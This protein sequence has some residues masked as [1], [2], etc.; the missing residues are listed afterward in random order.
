MKRLAAA[1]AALACACGEGRSRFD[2]GDPARMDRPVWEQ[3]VA[4]RDAAAEAPEDALALL[5]LGMA[6]D[7]NGLYDLAREVY[8]EAARLDPE[9]ARAHYHLGRMHQTLGDF[10]LALAALDRAA[11]LAPEYEPVHWRRGVVCLD[12]ARLDEAQAHFERARELAPGSVSGPVGLARVALQRG[13]AQRAVAL[14]EELLAAHPRERYARDLLAR[15]WQRLG[16]PERASSIA[17]AGEWSTAAWTDPWE[18]ETRAFAAGYAE[19]MTRAKELLT[20]G[21]YAEAVQLALPLLES[22]PRDITVQGLLTA[23]WVKLGEHDRALAMLEESARTSPEHYRILM[24][25][26]IVHH[27]KG[28]LDEAV[29]HLSRAVELYPSFA[30]GQAFLG[31]VYLQLEQF[32]PAEAALAQAL[33]LGKNDLDTVL[34]LGR[35]RGSLGR[36]EAAAVTFQYALQRYPEAATPWGYLAAAQAELGQLE[37]SRA[38]LEELKRRSP[39]HPLVAGVTAMLAERGSKP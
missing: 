22:Y 23:A 9:L 21:A 13:E 34:L 27:A 15:A 12:L 3:L 28:N 18:G 4:L 30:P 2:L 10:E 7:A 33:S 26:G 20:G 25:L 1:L 8:A 39:D 36:L 19:T 32:E 37:A 11:A 5:R 35:A 29:R 6:A 16:E 38:S 24:N 17:L 31:E 14:M